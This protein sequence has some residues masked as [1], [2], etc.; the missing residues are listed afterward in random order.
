MRECKQTLEQSGTLF[1]AYKAVTSHTADYLIKNKDR[2]IV[3]DPKF[4]IA[5]EED[6]SSVDRKVKSQY[7]MVTHDMECTTDDRVKTA[8]RSAILLRCLTST[9]YLESADQH[10]MFFMRLLYHFQACF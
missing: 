8:I 9:G 10:R 1:L 3:D 5:D 4:V 7:N 2:L 6:M